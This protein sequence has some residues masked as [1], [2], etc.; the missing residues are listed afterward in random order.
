MNTVVW[1]RQLVWSEHDARHRRRRRFA[2]VMVGLCI[3]GLSLDLAT[4]A[5]SF[6]DLGFYYL[7]GGAQLQ[8]DGR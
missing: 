2:V 1:N 3:V 4:A 7:F 5:W 8:P 6:G